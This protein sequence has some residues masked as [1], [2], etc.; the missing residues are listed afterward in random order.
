M[1][2]SGE[3]KITVDPGP[4]ATAQP[5]SP[6][7]PPRPRTH[8][9]LNASPV[10]P[11]RQKRHDA[12]GWALFRGS[13]TAP[14]VPSH[15]RPTPGAGPSVRGPTGPSP[16]PEPEELAWLEFSV[17]VRFLAETKARHGGRGTNGGRPLPTFVSPSPHLPHPTGPPAK[18]QNPRRD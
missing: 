10:R 9:P 14:N 1:L 15:G 17:P 6:N 11:R 13:R 16:R 8:V 3:K 7:L 18:I 4:G 12:G 2:A 5:G